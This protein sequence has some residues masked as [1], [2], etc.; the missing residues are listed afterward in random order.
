[1]K[2]IGNKG[3][4]KIEFMTMIAVIAILIALGVKLVADN[5]K[6]YGAFRNLANSFANN[7]A[8]YKDQYPRDD[9]TYILDDLIEKGFSEELKNPIDTTEYCDRFESYVEVPEPNNKKVTL[10]CGEYIV[11]GYQSSGYKVYEVT[12][13][14]TEKNNKSNDN[15]VL[16]NYTIDG[17][18]VFG[19][20]YTTRTFLEKYY[21][22]NGELISSPYDVNS[23]NQKLITKKVYREKTLVKDFS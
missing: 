1:M 3:F 4:S 2:K 19:E 9:N 12:E 7:V 22:K 16:Y 17:N 18:E 23:G 6:N 20:Y 11:E 14:T 8:R 10:I 13:W 21:E 15:N 5:S